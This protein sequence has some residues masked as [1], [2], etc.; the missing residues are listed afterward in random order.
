M[1]SE[2]QVADP[3]VTDP[4]VTAPEMQLSV[5]HRLQHLRCTLGD[6]LP[7]RVG[8][9]RGVKQGVHKAD[10]RGTGTQVIGGVLQRHSRRGDDVQEGEGAERLFNPRGQCFP[11][12]SFT[13]VVPRL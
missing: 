1:K 4:L 6:S 13:S 11:N 12:A 9:V 10:R 8:D 5:A 3:L 2:R 7:V